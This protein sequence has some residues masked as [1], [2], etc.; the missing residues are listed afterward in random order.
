MRKLDDQLEDQEVDQVLNSKFAKENH[1]PVQRDTK[2][3]KSTSISL[4]KMKQNQIGVNR[5]NQVNQAPSN[6]YFASICNNE[7]SSEES[8]DEEEDGD[9]EVTTNNAQ[10]CSDEL[11]NYFLASNN[12]NNKQNKKMLNAKKQPGDKRDSNDLANLLVLNNDDEKARSSN[13]NTDIVLTIDDINKNNQTRRNK[14]RLS[15]E[16]D[17]IYSCPSSNENDASLANSNPSSIKNLKEFDD[18]EEDDDDEENQL[19]CHENEEEEDVEDD[20]EDDEDDD[21]EDDNEEDG[22]ECDGDIDRNMIDEMNE[23][24]IKDSINSVV[25]N[26]NGNFLN[27][28]NFY[29]SSLKAKVSIRFLNLIN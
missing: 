24:H 18:D 27:R 20:E 15:Q 11:K 16:H 14:M 10:W 8:S 28:I 12:N 22:G 9:N 5:N 19:N 1:L 3:L 6:A 26:E 17:E 2:Q 4:K 23:N 21:D 25:N 7:E 13:M 29:F